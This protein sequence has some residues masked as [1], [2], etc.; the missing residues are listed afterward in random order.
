M[1]FLHFLSGAL[2]VMLCIRISGYLDIR[3]FIQRIILIDYNLVPCQTADSVVL[4]GAL[5]KYKTWAEEDMMVII[6]SRTSSPSVWPTSGSWSEASQ[7][8]DG[9]HGLDCQILSQYCGMFTSVM[10]AGA[11]FKYKDSQC[12]RTIKTFQTINFYSRITTL[13]RR[14]RLYAGLL[15]ILNLNRTVETSPPPYILCQLIINTQLT[16]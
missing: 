4:A 16:L 10:E 2:A 6:I 11:S 8:T 3:M 7:R 14:A 5:G 15:S 12:W 9:Q 1:D 13:D